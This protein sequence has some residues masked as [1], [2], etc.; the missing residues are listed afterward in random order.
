MGL[1]IKT[2]SPFL[3]LR[4]LVVA[5]LLPPPV[6]SVNEEDIRKMATLNTLSANINPNIVVAFVSKSDVHNKAF[7]SYKK[8]IDHLDETSN[9]I[10]NFPTLDEAKAWVEEAVKTEPKSLGAELN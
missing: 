2:R 7:N 5:W 1:F 4:V 3:L 6:Y 9:E 10:R 8:H